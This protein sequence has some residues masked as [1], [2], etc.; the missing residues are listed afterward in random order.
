MKIKEILKVGLLPEDHVLPEIYYTKERATQYDRNSRIKKIQREMTIR[1]LEILEAEPP[2]LV[3]DLGC[4]SGRSMQAIV[5]AGFMVKGIDIADSML[6]IAE[7]KGLEVYKANFT[8]EIP[9]P[10]N[11]FNYVISISTLQWIFHGFKPGEILEK[12]KKT[13]REIYRVLKPEGKAIFQFYPKN[14]EQLDLAG[15]NLRKA[16]FQVTKVIDDPKIPKRRKIFLLCS[17]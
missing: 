10:S 8:Q 3:L 5:E 15:K 4:G 1:A 11:T 9:F 14:T 2:A 6:S 16:G 12:V 7:E 13:G 17:K